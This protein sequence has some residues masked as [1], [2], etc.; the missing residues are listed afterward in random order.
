MTRARPIIGIT[1]NIKNIRDI[2]S[3]TINVFYTQGLADHCDVVPVLIPGLHPDQ[4]SAGASGFLRALDGILFTGGVANVHPSH[5]GHTETAEHA[6]FDPQ[7]DGTSLPLM[8]AALDVDMPILAICR[9]FQEMNVVCGGTLHP[10]IHT[11]P[12]RMNHSER[13][14]VPR[15]EI[16]AARHAINIVAGGELHQLL[17]AETAQVNS[18]HRQ[19][20]DTLGEG[21]RIE[22]RAPD[23]TIE[24]ISHDGKAFAMGTQWHPEYQ[25]GENTIS[26]PLFKAFEAAAEDY[27]TKKSA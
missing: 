5:Y 18:L 26:A 13:P 4:T 21:L 19:G 12:G 9:G 10:A 24:A 7:R 6:P 2:P 11:L 27:M 17:G 8:R 20:I 16:F 25:T 14:D 23:G 1:T 15:E 22:A 3:H